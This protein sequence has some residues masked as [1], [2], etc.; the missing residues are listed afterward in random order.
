VAYKTRHE[1]LEENEELKDSLGALYD[2]IA[3]TLNLN[4]L[5]DKVEEDEEDDEE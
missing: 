3:E 1:L 4:E 5:E 2:Q